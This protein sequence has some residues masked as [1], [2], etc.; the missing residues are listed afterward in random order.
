[1]LLQRLLKPSPPR[2][3]TLPMDLS[4]GSL[5]S[6]LLVSSIGGGLFLYGKASGKMLILAAGLVVSCLPFF[7]SSPLLLWGLTAAT[8]VPLYTL[9][10]SL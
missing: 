4:F 9:R 2:A 1:M 8:F 5:F 7:V 3:D 6:G 10:H